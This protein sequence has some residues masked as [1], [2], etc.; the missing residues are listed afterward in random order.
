MKR[1]DSP[2]SCCP[3]EEAMEVFGGKW[4]VGIIH[5]LSVGPL[6]FNELRS[7]L[8]RIT[9]KM[10]TQQL[11]HLQRYGLIKREQFSEIPPRVEYSLMTLGKS[12]FPLLEQITQWS[13]KHMH[14]LREAAGVYDAANDRQT[15]I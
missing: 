3:A 14:G 2:A 11:C 10:L 6:R 8:P 13:K 4:Q 9:Q 5:H 15:R 1:A 12:M 7:R